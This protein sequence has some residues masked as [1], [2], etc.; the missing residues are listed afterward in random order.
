MLQAARPH[1]TAAECSEA[2]HWEKN[3]QIIGFSISS[4]GVQAGPWRCAAPW[5]RAAGKILHLPDSAAAMGMLPAALQPPAGKW[6]H[7][8]ESCEGTRL[9]GTMGFTNASIK[10]R[11]G[12]AKPW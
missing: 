12:D 5:G 9:M 10:G 7:G 4:N 1:S 2:S 3:E 11:Q 8:H 6:G